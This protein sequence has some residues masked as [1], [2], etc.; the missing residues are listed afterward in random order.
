M[1]QI[2][3]VWFTIILGTAGGLP[4]FAGDLPKEG[5]FSV[6]CFNY[7]TFKRAAV[8]K[9]QVQRAFEYDGLCV[10][11]GLLDHMTGHCRGTSRLSDQTVHVV[12]FCVLNDND[13]DQIAEDF[14]ESFPNGAKEI[15][16]EAKLVAGT[17]KY[18]GITGEV[19]FVNTGGSFKAAA[20]NGLFAYGKV[21]GHYQLPK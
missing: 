8:G 5:T 11:E 9:T 17:G 3:T 21:E 13:G 4:A 10:G 2:A 16:G 14:D 20:D 15:R 6:T 19:K 7:G 12:S 1:R 18:E